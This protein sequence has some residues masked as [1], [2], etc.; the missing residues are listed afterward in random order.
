MVRMTGT[1]SGLIKRLLIEV[2]STDKLLKRHLP[3]FHSKMIMFLY[4]N[5]H[6]SKC[7][8][9]NHIIYCFTIKSYPHSEPLCY[10]TTHTHYY[11]PIT[12]YIRY[13]SHYYICYHT[14]GLHRCETEA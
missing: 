13:H 9:C 8:S 14:G 6:R 3:C 4:F 11:M 1:A 7:C 5:W 2:F 10:C 12:T